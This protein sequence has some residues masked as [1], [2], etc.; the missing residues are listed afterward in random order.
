M[1]FLLFHIFCKNSKSFYHI[2][3]FLKLPPNFYAKE[4]F[5]VICQHQ[6]HWRTDLI[7][8][9]LWCGCLA[10]WRI[11]PSQGTFYWVLLV[12]LQGCAVQLC[13]F[14]VGFSLRYGERA[15]VGP[16]VSSSV[17]GSAAGLGEPDR[18][19]SI[20]QRFLLPQKFLTSSPLSLL[21]SSVRLLVQGGRGETEKVSFVSWLLQH[22]PSACGYAY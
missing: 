6:M 17:M 5:L 2:F 10:Q 14:L 19:Q 20:S 4:A 22:G 3:L 21:K 16:C 7:F 11:I 12:C 15:V 1:D 8:T 18:R 9:S 13:P